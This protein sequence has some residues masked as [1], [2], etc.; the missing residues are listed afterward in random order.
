MASALN[1]ELIVEHPEAG[2]LVSAYLDGDG[3]VER[4]FGPHFGS[5]GAF[6]TKI[7][8]VDGRFDRA[9]RERAVEAVLVPPGAD[10]SRLERFVEEG[11]YMVTTGQQPGLFGGPLYNVSKALTAARL[12][13]AL[14]ARLGKPVVT[15]FWVSSEDHDW[16]EACHADVIGVDN[17]LHRVEV[18]APDPGVTPPIHRIRLRNGSAEAVSEFLGY[19]PKTDFSE[20]YFTLLREAFGP[21]RTLADGFHTTLQHLV[22]RFGVF[23]TDGV[24]PA[25]KQASLPV[26]LAELDRA[27]ELEAVLRAS[28]SAIE[29]AGY[30]LQ[31]PILEG[32]VNL[33]LEG[34]AGRERLYREAGGYRLRTSGERLSGDDVRARVAEDPSVLSPNVLLRPVIE[35]TLFPTLAY[36][37]G[38]GEMAYFAQLRDYFQAHGVAMPVIHPRWAA[39]PI[40]S[41]I[42]K[43]LDKFGLQPD[44][45]R[46]PFH[47]VAGD[48]ARE[49]MPAEV[50]AALGKLRGSIGSGLVELTKAVGAVDKTLAG[51]VQQVGSQAYAA[52]DDLEKKIVQAMKRESEIGLGQLE[53]A[54][55]HLYPLGK[56]A[57][58]V[59]SPFYYLS[60]YGG[61]VLDAMYDRF[62]LKLP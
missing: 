32:G 43:V 62:A 4:F 10:A 40:E 50:R 60:R 16:E 3:A 42:R 48:V 17:E 35:S 36:V 13:E 7:A 54:Q 22:G 47:E 29:D 34:P 26:L 18:A 55:I 9:A 37:G 23:F 59:Q 8:E 49:E 52:L 45:L 2:D 27:E 6:E 24:L 21:D 57:E 28:A 1:L 20:E 56:P 11:G 58:R 30:T 41:K 12:A 51:P 38:P 39:T 14:E 25:L 19:L 44:T 61:A 5:W 46:R 15:L 33:F 31:V 53:K